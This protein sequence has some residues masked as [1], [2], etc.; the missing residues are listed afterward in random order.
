MIMKCKF[1]LAAIA[2]SSLAACS[3]RLGEEQLK[4]GEA[5]NL[6]ISVSGAATKATNVTTEKKVNTLQVFVFGEGKRLEAYESV[7]GAES[8]DISILTGTKIIHALVNAP[9][10]KGVVDY[11]D[12]YGKLSKLSDNTLSNFVMEGRKQVTVKTTDMSETIEVS[13]MVSKISLVKVENKLD[14]VY[15]G[16]EFKLKRAYLINVAADRKYAAEGQTVPAPASWLN[17]MKY[18]DGLPELTCGTYAEVIASK[19]VSA[20]KHSFY[21][22]PNPTSG[23]TS[24]AT[25]SARRTRLVVEVELDKTL[26]YYPVTL[27]VLAQNTEYQVSLVVTRPGSNGPDIPY[28]PGDAAVSIKI[29]DWVD[30]KDVTEEI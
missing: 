26:Y 19:S 25:W 22:Y 14:D 13:R 8:L 1:I 18:T 27:P 15:S 6:E 21:C 29:A 10:V 4:S 17:M 24:S 11:D 7:S 30:G 2:V 20:I 5:V 9:A 3:E 16:V 12:F 23:D 28:N